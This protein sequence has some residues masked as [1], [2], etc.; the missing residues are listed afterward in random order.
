MALCYTRNKKKV[1]ENQVRCAITACSLNFV[2]GQGGFASNYTS[3]FWYNFK[4]NYSYHFFNF[5]NTG[6]RL[7]FDCC[8]L[9]CSQFLLTVP[10]VHLNNGGPGAF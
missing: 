9:A 3:N 7:F 10:T 6:E 2:S 1:P 5:A 4:I 8:Q